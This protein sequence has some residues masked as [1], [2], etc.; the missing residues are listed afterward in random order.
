MGKL[1]NELQSYKNKMTNL[2]AA[3]DT[4]FCFDEKGEKK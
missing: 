4:A 3:I 1:K 2:K